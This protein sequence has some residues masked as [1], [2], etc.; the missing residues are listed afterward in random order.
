MSHDII[1]NEAEHNAYADGNPYIGPEAVANGV[2]A[3][4]VGEWDGFR[5]VIEELIDAGDTVITF[6]RY[7]GTFKRTGRAQNTQVAHV[8]R[9]AGGKA[10]RFQQHADTLHLAHVMGLKV[11]AGA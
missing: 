11:E 1:W 7:G 5:V 4:C 8:W 2:F 3:R 6:G 10:V 9:V